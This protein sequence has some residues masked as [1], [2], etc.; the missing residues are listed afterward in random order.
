MAEPDPCRQPA[1]LVRPVVD[2]ALCEA[3]GDCAAVCPYDVF[4]IERIASDVFAGLPWLSKAKVFV[5]GMRTATTPNADAC[6][7]CGLCVQACPERAIRLVGSA[8]ADGVA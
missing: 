8:R 6:R 1:G 7:A 5:H 2:P 3:K 4:R